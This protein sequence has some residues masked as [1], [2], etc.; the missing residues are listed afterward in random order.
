MRAS[1]YFPART[2]PEASC[3]CQPFLSPFCEKRIGRSNVPYLSVSDKKERLRFDY[4]GGEEA[5]ALAKPLL[6]CLY[7]DMTRHCHCELRAELFCAFGTQMRH[8]LKFRI[9]LHPIT[10]RQIN[11]V[12]FRSQRLEALV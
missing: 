12:P 4:R 3:C 8:I 9:A 10:C 6:A 1:A 7:G 11:H 5:R 2:R